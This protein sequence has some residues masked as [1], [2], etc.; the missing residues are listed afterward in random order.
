VVGSAAGTR[1]GSPQGARLR[2]GSVIVLLAVSL[3]GL[4]GFVSASLGTPRFSSLLL[5]APLL[6]TYAVVGGAILWRRGHPIAWLLLAM[7]LIFAAD[8]LLDALM[9]RPQPP[10][11]TPAWRLLLVAKG[12]LFPLFVMLIPALGLRFP[13]GRPLSRRWRI[14]EV[15]YLVGV[16]SVVAAMML[17]PQV[18]GGS[19]E[20]PG[21]SVPNPLWTPGRAGLSST[22]EVVAGV[23]LA[24][25]I[26]LSLVALGLRFWRS[27]GRE[28]QQLRWLVYPIA[29]VLAS[30]PLVAGAAW[31]VFGWDATATV[32]GLYS[33]LG[34]AVPAIGM[35]A[36]ITR[37]GLYD[38]Q[39]LISRTLAYAA[40]TLV[41][42][43]LYAGAVLVI[44]SGARALTGN[45]DDLT[46]ALSTL[47]VAAGFGPARSRLQ[48]WVD[49][50]FN[51]RRA[52]AGATVERFAQRLRDEV[53]LQQ[54]GHELTAS[55][56]EALEPRSV[57]VVLT[58]GGAP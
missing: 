30:W 27:R 41:L 24:P 14:V 12:P 3:A 34:L 51:R 5:A 35:G 38:L 17:T 19:A 53:D 39:R 22:L 10:G 56:A 46:V 42:A 36:A 57:T 48:R 54:I 9:T 40:L 1:P 26:V 49:R 16:T 32:A 45:A 47:V 18:N 28:R 29:T 31:L 2:R 8:G 6:T 23:T 55:V 44:G 4:V 21:W 37:H 50:R 25:A 52:D 33:T 15:L 13:D 11:T 20:G 7:G 43:A 58:P